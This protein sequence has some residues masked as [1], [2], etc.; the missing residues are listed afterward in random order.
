MPGV[1][2]R[3]RLFIVCKREGCEQ[4]REVNRPYK[5]RRGGYCSSRCASLATQNIRKADAS[6]G[7]RV[8]ALRKRQLLKTRLDGMQPLDIFRLGYARG[9]NA[10]WRALRK[11]YEL[12]PRA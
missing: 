2:R 1:T 9:L 5:Q 4:L 10:K 7:G 12:V 3:V 11:A 8:T 6:R